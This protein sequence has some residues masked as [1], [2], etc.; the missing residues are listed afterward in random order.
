M[1]RQGDGLAKKV[2]GIMPQMELA[3]TS[4]KRRRGC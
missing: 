3:Y 4:Y 1:M 2:G